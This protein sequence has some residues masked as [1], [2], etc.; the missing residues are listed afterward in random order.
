MNIFY[1]EFDSVEKKCKLIK[2]NFQKKELIWNKFNRILMFS[3]WFKYRLNINMGA[4]LN[5]V[6]EIIV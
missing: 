1:N 2:F 5:L 3:L 6:E 4:F